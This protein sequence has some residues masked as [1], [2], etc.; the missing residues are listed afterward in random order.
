MTG[1]TSVGPA[2]E[3]SRE[4]LLATLHLLRSQAALFIGYLDV[5]APGDREALA[6][7]IRSRCEEV[8]LEVDMHLSTLNPGVAS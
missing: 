1:A 7:Y 6:A 2:P 3:A 8:M 5:T 4:V